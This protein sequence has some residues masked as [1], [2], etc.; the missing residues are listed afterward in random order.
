MSD[1]EFRLRSFGEEVMADPEITTDR[2]AAEFDYLTAAERH[3]L[4]ADP[5]WEKVK[6]DFLTQYQ[7]LANELL[8]PRT[9]T[10]EKVERI[11]GRMD[12][13]AWV[14]QYP[15]QVER[16][17]DQARAQMEALAQVEEVTEHE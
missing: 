8:M 16:K 17:M 15:E 7:T 10:M 3:S 4:F 11:R 1:E 14:L 6:E 13:L 2:A 5:A 12:T 9:D